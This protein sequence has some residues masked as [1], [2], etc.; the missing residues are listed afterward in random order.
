M[1]PKKTAAQKAEEKR[2]KE[3]EEAKAKAAEEARLAAEAEKRRI[4]AETLAAER[5]AARV[6]ELEIDTFWLMN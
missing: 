3:E 2:L 4:E 6:L 5:R 1:G